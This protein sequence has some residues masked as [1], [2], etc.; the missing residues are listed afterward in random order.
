MEVDIEYWKIVARGIDVENAKLDLFVS[1]KHSRGVAREAILRDLLVTQTPHPFVVSTGFVRDNYPN[2]I[3]PKQCDVLVYDPRDGQPLYQLNEFVVTCPK[4]TRL[5]I[6]VK[7]N[8][9]KR[10]LTEI[11]QAKRTFCQRLLGFAFQGQVFKTFCTTVASE[12]KSRARHNVPGGLTKMPECIAVHK[13]NY[14]AIRADPLPE[15]PKQSYLLVNFS[16]K[17][18]AA[19]AH[20]MWAYTQ[21]LNSRT[22]ADGELVEWFNSLPE[23]SRMI[24]TPD[25]KLKHRSLARS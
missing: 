7:S 19:T 10:Y 2:R 20:F 3:A 16:E 17:C 23:A 4:N 12:L 13:Q 9:S 18:G 8:L 21:L 22:L 6:E 24:I 14:F 5:A 25:G 15:P 11:I 1:H